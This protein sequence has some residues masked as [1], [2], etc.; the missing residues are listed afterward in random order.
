MAEFYGIENVGHP[1]EY[2]ISPNAQVFLIKSKNK[3][4]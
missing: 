1:S 2:W 3:N 4:S